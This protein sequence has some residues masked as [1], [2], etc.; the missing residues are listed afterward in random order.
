MSN[1]HLFI[2]KSYLHSDD[3]LVRTLIN[4]PTYDQCIILALL[5][6]LFYYI[7]P[8]KALYRTQNRGQVQKILQINI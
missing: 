7:V 3:Y 6:F 8:A 5:L 1:F 2:K 4:A